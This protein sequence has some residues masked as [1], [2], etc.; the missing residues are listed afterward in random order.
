MS[1]IRCLSFRARL[2][3]ESR[4]LDC[5]ELLICCRHSASWATG[6]SQQPDSILFLGPSRS[7][8]EYASDILPQ[9]GVEE[10]VLQTTF[11]EWVSSLHSKRLS[12]RSRIWNHLLDKGELR[13]YDAEAESIKGSVAMADALDRHVSQL[14]RSVRAALRDVQPFRVRISGDTQGAVTKGDI[15]DATADAL[16]GGGSQP[17]LNRRRLRFFRL[18][19][20]NIVSRAGGIGR[21]RPEEARQYRRDIE[22]RLE[23]SPVAGAWPVIDFR[24]EYA[25]LLLDPERF[26]RL[27]SNQVSKET[28]EAT[29]LGLR[30]A[31]SHEFNDP[32]RAALT[33]LDHLLND[34]ITARFNHIVVDEAQDLSPLDFKLLRLASTNG[35][36]TILGDTSQRLMPHRGIRRWRD[37]NRVLGR[38]ITTVQH[39]RLSYRATKQITLF[40]NRILRL[41]DTTIDAPQPFDRDGHRVEYVTHNRSEDMY[42]GVV[43]E[44]T[45][46]RTLQGLEGARIGI[47]VRDQR[48]LN[49]F[50]EYCQ[51]HGLDEVAKFGEESLDSPTVLARISVTQGLEYDAVVVLGV[52]ESFHSTE[53]NRKLLY[54]ACTRAKHYLAFHW[55]GAQ[56][57]I[58]NEISDRGI[59]R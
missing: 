3:A 44:L 25:H 36:F 22:S 16:S 17:M 6:Q 38:A 20:D 7:F 2:A 57:P 42:R 27:T 24:D 59:S 9:L 39:A 11:G 30:G 51:Q 53:F 34:T 49:A 21:R 19:T 35:W 55:F 32:D 26:S 43:G 40:N 23:N 37:L 48:N 33:Y 1:T 8:L 10:R 46:I 5:T 47:L 14:A 52:N 28:A 54:L 41:F 29:A 45:R 18:L 58:L 56:S 13:D 4:I 50:Y 15:R 12:I 31:S